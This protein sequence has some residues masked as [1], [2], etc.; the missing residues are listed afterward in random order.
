MVSVGLHL[1]PRKLL[2]F[3]FKA[4]LDPDPAFHSNKDPDPA[5]QNNADP[6]PSLHNAYRERD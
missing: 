3:D 2:N 4:E 5:S 6:D 1:E